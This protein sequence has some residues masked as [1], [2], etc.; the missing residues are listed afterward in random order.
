MVVGYCAATPDISVS[1][2][3]EIEQ[4]SVLMKIILSCLG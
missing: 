2:A 3:E 1:T 4:N